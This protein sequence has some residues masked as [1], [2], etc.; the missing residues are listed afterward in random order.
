VDEDRT[1]SRLKGSRSDLI[2]PAIAAHHGR[3]VN[4]TRAARWAWRLDRAANAPKKTRPH[5][6]APG[7]KGT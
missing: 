4:R 6:F 2:D 7:D 1:L 5:L 3:I